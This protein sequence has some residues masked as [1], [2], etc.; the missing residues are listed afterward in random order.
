MRKTPP[1]TIIPYSLSTMNCNLSDIKTKTVRYYT[2][3]I[4]LL[5]RNYT[6][7]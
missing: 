3:R 5:W 6:V 1:R 2:C 4:E 7:L